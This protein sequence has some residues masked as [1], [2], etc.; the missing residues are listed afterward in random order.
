MKKVNF[1]GVVIP[2][3][4]FLKKK[5]QK[6]RRKKPKDRAKAL[7]ASPP[8]IIAGTTFRDTK[9]EI[10]VQGVDDS[11][12]MSAQEE[13]LLNS[14]HRAE[15]KAMVARDNKLFKPP[16]SRLSDASDSLLLT[17]ADLE[18]DSQT[19]DLLA[20][21]DTKHRTDEELLELLA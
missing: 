7:G 3:F 16:P 2:L 14:K 18:T 15:I 17:G 4:F 20:D 8:S 9:V 19:E 12:F 10:D 13:K 1:V 6:R 11:D 5:K 21:T